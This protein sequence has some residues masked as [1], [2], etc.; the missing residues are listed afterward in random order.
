MLPSNEK[1]C[2]NDEGKLK[3]IGQFF[4]L[5]GG[6]IDP[7]P[8]KRLKVCVKCGKAFEIAEL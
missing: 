8:L 4:L 3:S 2:P 1:K 5:G 6:S 7:R